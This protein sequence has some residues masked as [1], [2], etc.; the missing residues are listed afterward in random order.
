MEKY[1]PTTLAIIP[2]GIPGIGKSKVFEA[3]MKSEAALKLF[4][5][6]SV[7][8]DDIRKECIDKYMAA[9][10]HARQDDAFK[11]TQGAY[12]SAFNAALG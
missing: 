6:D 11:A 7:S 12:K 10:P 1:T 2:M 5:F 3:L 4:H 9:K 8:S